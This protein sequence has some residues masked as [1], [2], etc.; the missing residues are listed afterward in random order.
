MEAADADLDP[1]LFARALNEFKRV[2]RQGPGRD[3]VIER[4]SKRLEA[5]KKKV[6]KKN[7]KPGE[8]HLAGKGR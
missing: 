3:R 1:K 5:L 2:A 8:G 4:F 6:E 7:G